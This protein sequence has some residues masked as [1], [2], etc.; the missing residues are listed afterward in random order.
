MGRQWE[1]FWA[2]LGG[3]NR[4]GEVVPT[5]FQNVKPVP[6][7]IMYEY[8]AEEGSAAPKLHFPRTLDGKLQQT[9]QL[10]IADEIPKITPE[11]ASLT[12]TGIGTNTG[13]YVKL[14]NIRNVSVSS[15]DILLLTADAAPSDA[16]TLL[17]ITIAAGDELMDTVGSG[18]WSQTMKG[19]LYLVASA[20]SRLRGQ[21]QVLRIQETP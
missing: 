3:T 11:L 8:G 9:N 13:D 19:P 10:L 14:V 6:V 18:A 5:N 20:A 21:Y 16:N 4:A 15:A 2:W 7:A 1:A 12:R 17:S